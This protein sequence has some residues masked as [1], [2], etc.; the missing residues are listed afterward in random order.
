MRGSVVPF[1]IVAFSTLVFAARSALADL[2]PISGQITAFAEVHNNPGQTDTDSP[3]P[4]VLGAGYGSFANQANASL[5]GVTASIS[6]QTTRSLGE[7]RFDVSGQIL[8]GGPTL[9]GEVGGQLDETF[10]LSAAADLELLHV[11]GGGSAVTFGVELLDA[12]SQPVNTTGTAL[13]PAGQYRLRTT[14]TYF[15]VGFP[16]TITQTVV[17]SIPEPTT[18]LA[19]AAIP[20]LCHRRQRAKSRR[21]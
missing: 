8:I 9:T 13:I 3:P 7:L 2:V 4:V 18:L 5:V 10:L 16:A 19:F 20:L 12:S 11:N 6:L 1:A 14:N 15:E 17:L 21:Y